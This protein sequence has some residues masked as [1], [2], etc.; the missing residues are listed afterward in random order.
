MRDY[1][2]C[3]AGNCE[4]I[5][6]D[7]EGNE[8]IYEEDLVIPA[9]NHQW[10][11]PEYTW[12]EDLSAV[13]GIRTC[14]NGCGETQSETVTPQGIVTRQP[15]CSEADHRIYIAPF[16]KEGFETQTRTG[17]D[18]PALG[19]IDREDQGSGK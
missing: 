12:A 4:A 6:A 15:S 18:I 13:T 16:I 8:R 19:H 2:K 3:T 14:S 7:S 11:A 1:Y 5:F 10:S 17:D 9:K